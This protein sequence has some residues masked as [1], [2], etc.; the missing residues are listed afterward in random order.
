[1]SQRMA[2]SVAQGMHHM[3]HQSTL[4]ETNEDLF[5]DTH[6]ELQERMQNPIA[7]HAEMMGDILY[8]F[9]V[10]SETGQKLHSVFLHTSIV[11]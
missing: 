10:G 1:M 6:L 5:H 2:E 11:V 7:F 9:N 4:S 8:E 3:A